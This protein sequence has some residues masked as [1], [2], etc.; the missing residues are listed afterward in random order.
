MEQ[1]EQPAVNNVVPAKHDLHG[2]VFAEK[3]AILIAERDRQ[4]QEIESKFQAQL[5]NLIAEYNIFDDNITVVS[6]CTLCYD[7]KAV[8]LLKPCMH[9]V[10]QGCADKITVCPWDRGQI[11]KSINT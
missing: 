2:S 5:S 9:R 7:S 8:V 11:E 3:K 1:I 6:E 10:C 4:I